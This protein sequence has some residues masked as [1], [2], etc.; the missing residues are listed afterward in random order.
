MQILMTL[1]A[2]TAELETEQLLNY[3]QLFWAAVACLD[4]TSEK[5]FVE[6]VFNALRNTFLRFI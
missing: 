5:E 2:M 4:T 6:V 1:N 3:P